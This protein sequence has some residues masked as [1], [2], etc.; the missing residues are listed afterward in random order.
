[1]LKQLL[2]EIDRADYLS[3]ST[4]ASQLGQPRPLIEEGFTALV[5]MGYLA[6]EAGLNCQDLPCG[7]CPYASMCQKDP[8]K[9]W[10]VTEKGQTLLASYQATS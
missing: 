5:R 2:L 8:L 3:M 10:S 1:M 4:L 6:E 7:R 9:T